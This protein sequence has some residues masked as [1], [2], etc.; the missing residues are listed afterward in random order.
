MINK[1]ELLENIERAERELEEMRNTLKASSW[2]AKDIHVGLVVDSST[3][4]RVVVLSAGYNRGE[5]RYMIGGCNGNPFL[6]FSDIDSSGAT[7]AE[8][9]DMFNNRNKI[10]VGTLKINTHSIMGLL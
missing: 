9:A 6:P 3:A 8:V 4:S 1:Q 2:E 10:K 5:K 7:A